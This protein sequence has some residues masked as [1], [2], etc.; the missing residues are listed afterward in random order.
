MATKQ[1]WLERGRLRRA[2]AEFFRAD[3]VRYRQALAIDQ[4]R[5]QVRVNGLQ[6]AV[7]RPVGVEQSVR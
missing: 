6:C 3:R 2:V 1:L 4:V 5:R 7:R